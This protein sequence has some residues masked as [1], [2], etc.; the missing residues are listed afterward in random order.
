MHRPVC[1]SIETLQHVLIGTMNAQIHNVGNISCSSG[2]PRIVKYSS[3][4]IPEMS[5]CV[6]WLRL[7]GSVVQYLKIQQRRSC[8]LF[9]LLLVNGKKSGRTD[10]HGNE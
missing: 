5:K 9:Y 6:T 4:F 3:S 8:S 2:R 10:E 1:L 7:F